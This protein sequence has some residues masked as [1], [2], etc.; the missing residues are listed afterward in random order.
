MLA[1]TDRQFERYW[2]M[3]LRELGLDKYLEYVAAAYPEIIDEAKRKIRE[4][5]QSSPTDR[6][7]EQVAIEYVSANL[8]AEKFPCLV[9]SRR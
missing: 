9:V 7:C 1:F 3:I 8:S 2:G 4:L 5:P 6:R